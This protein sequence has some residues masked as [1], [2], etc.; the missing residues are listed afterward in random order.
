MDKTARYEVL[1]LAVPEITQDE[2]KDLEKQLEKVVQKEKGVIISFERWGK[3]KLAY[4]V[5]KKEYG[6]YFLSRFTIPKNEITLREITNT[7][8]VKFDAI[9]MR[10]AISTLDATTSLEYQRPRS[11]EEAPLVAEGNF[12]ERR[13]K[14]YDQSDAADHMGD[15]EPSEDFGSG[16]D[17]QD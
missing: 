15:I 10:S 14:S 13:H 16:I 5:R 3:Y 1:I 17:E 12:K 9:V 8:S 6:V 4:P 2:T 7:L 11:L